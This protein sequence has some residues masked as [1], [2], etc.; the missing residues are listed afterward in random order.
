[1]YL[2]GFDVHTGQ[3][4][5][6]ITS[7]GVY[8]DLSSLIHDV[9]RHLDDVLARDPAAWHFWSEAARFFTRADAS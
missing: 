5:V 1:V 7:L 4:W 2:T 3:R 6:H 8:E 9:F